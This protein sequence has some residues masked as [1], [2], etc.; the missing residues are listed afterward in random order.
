MTEQSIGAALGAM[1]DA[2]P[3]VVA[4][5]DDPMVKRVTAAFRANKSLR[6]NFS[7]LHKKI[8]I[9]HELARYKPVS[10]EGTSDLVDAV[11]ARDAIRNAR[12]S[13]VAMLL[14]VHR[15]QA[16][17]VDIR[18]IVGVYLS[19]PDCPCMPKNKKLTV[20][21]ME[22]LVDVGLY[23]VT[24]VLASCKE[25]ATAITTALSDMDACAKTLD[26]WAHAHKEHAF[27]S[28]PQKGWKED[29]RAKKRPLG[30]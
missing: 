30:G 16:K 13:L 11:A 17:C 6:L 8:Q 23:E 12:S 22:A 18:R 15:I 20:K 5:K 24:K 7:Q 28:L 4:I 25:A 14:D 2:T 19:D 26:F 21:D 29:D 27:L 10:I 9:V 1:R 3:I